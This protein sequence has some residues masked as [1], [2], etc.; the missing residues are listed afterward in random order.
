MV[1]LQQ[2]HAALRARHGQLHIRYCCLPYGQKS[3][4]T[5]YVQRCEHTL[6]AAAAGDMV[7]L[8]RKKAPSSVK[9]GALTCMS[10]ITTKPTKEVDTEILWM[11]HLSARGQVAE[12]SEADRAAAEDLHSCGRA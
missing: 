11:M 2:R 3:C 12:G 6:K 5:P 9:H 10:H 1:A 7:R 4:I 8:T